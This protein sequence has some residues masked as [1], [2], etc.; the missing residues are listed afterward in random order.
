MMN[1]VLLGGTGYVGSAI[2]RNLE[3]EN[4]GNVQV[5][6]LVRGDAERIHSGIVKT[7]K[8][9]LPDK[10]P[11]ELFFKKPHV[12]IHFA[13]K[14]V[15]TD[16]SGFY[17]SNVEGTGSLIEALPESSRGILYGSSMSV[18]GQGQQVSVTED[19]AVKPETEL[20]K[21]RVKA[22]R[23][24]LDEMEMSKKTGIVLRPRFILG[25]GDKYTLKG[26][27]SLA[28]KGFV[29]GSGKQ[30]FSIIDVDDYAKIIISLAK[31]ILTG[32]KGEKTI[33]RPLNIGYESPITLESILR[34]ICEKNQLP[35]PTKKIPVFKFLPV[36]LRMLPIP[37]MSGV[38]TK[39]ELVGLS[40]SGS[41]KALENIIG[42]EITR[43]N[44]VDVFTAIM[45]NSYG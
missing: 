26:F 11:H 12:V 36:F 19:Q 39:L 15:D 4:A 18:Y 7:I 33:C 14:Q 3:I 31:G 24:I 27:K 22:E 9:N 23:L 41:V 34:R 2:I 6:A 25:N 13:T 35:F 8:G 20:S 38:A 29:V 45:E 44:P 42:R 40:H 21:T 17:T 1:I 43:K 28:E 32:H 5:R 30:S 10:I 37:A 16:N